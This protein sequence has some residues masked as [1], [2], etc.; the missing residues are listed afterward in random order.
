MKLDGYMKFLLTLSIIWLFVV[1]FRL[2]DNGNYAEAQKEESGAWQVVMSENPGNPIIKINT[3]TGDSF[4]LIRRSL[5][6]IANKEVSAWD[7]ILFDGKEYD[8]FKE[9]L[10][11]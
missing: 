1:L 8:K 2:T 11:K 5:L 7:Y 9:D 6:P 10:K 3:Q 4:Q